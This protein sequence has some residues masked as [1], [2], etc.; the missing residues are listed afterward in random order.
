MGASARITG[1]VNTTLHAN[2]FSGNI[3]DA[4]YGDQN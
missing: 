3:A 2:T 4:V 1:G